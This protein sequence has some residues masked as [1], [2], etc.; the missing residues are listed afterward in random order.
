[1]NDFIMAA[2]GMTTNNLINIATEITQANIST[3]KKSIKSMSSGQLNWKVSKNTW[4]INEILA[5]LNEYSKHYH[6]TFLHKIENTR[7]KSS[8]EGF[9]SSPLGK[10][11]WKAMKLGNAN[12]IKRKFKSPKECNPILSPNILKGNQINNFLNQQKKLLNIIEKC[13]C[14]NIRRIKIPTSRSKVVRLRL[15][16]ALLFVAYH[17]ER[18]VQQIINLKKNAYFPSK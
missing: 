14:V 9:I 5:H 10:A 8:K 12:N 4:N 16:D 3:V 11:A 18:H 15:G 6:N 7:F 1:M 17:N 13:K 2:I